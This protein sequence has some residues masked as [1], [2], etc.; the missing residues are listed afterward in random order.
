VSNEAQKAG[1][2]AGVHQSPSNRFSS[3][4]MPQMP[5][6]LSLEKRVI[7]LLSRR[8]EDLVERRRQDVRDQADEQAMSKSNVA[9]AR[10][11]DKSA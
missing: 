7:T 2:D 6:L 10:F 3:P 9:C 8:A 4:E 1:W 5:I 11:S